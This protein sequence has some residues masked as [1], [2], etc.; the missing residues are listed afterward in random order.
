MLDPKLEDSLSRAIDL[1]AESLHEFVSLEHVLLALLENSEAKE[2][3]KALSVDLDKLRNHLQDFL[4]KDLPRMENQLA[5]KDSHWKPELTIAFHR[6]LQRAAIQVQS[7][8]R[9]SVSTGSLLVSLM[10]EKDSHAVYFIEQQGVTQFDIINYLSHGI[11]KNSR[12]PMETKKLAIDGL[13]QEEAESV[14]GDPLT[15]FAVNL[16]EKVKA[17]KVDPLIGRADVIERAIQILSRRTKNNPLLVGEAGVGKTAIADGLAQKIVDKE[18]PPHLQNAVIYSLDLG[19]LIAGTKYRGDFEQR[20]KSLLQALAEKD[21]PILFIDEIHTLVG[22]GGTSGGAMDAS[23]LLKPALADGSLSCIGSTTYK[24]FKNH[25]EKDRALARRFQKIDLKEPTVEETIEILKGLKKNYEDFHQVKYSK[26]SIEAA[27]QL[28]AKH[29][30]GRQLPDKAID[31]IDE[32]G[33]RTRIKSGH[34]SISVK[35]VERVVA[36]MAQIPTQSVSASDKEKLKTLQ[37]DLKSVIFGQDSAIDKL[38][39]A[40]KLSRTGLGREQKPIGSF[41]FAG[42]TGVG[43]TEVAKQLAKNLSIPFLRFDMSE[44]ME[45]H[46]VSRLIGAPPGYVGFEEGGLLTDSVIKNPHSV[47]LMDEIEKA[48]IDLIN[49][50]LQVMDSGR[51]TDSTGRTVDFSNVILILTSNTGAYEASRATLGIQSDTSSSKSMDAIKKSF[52]PEFLN[53]LDA[54]IEFKELNKELLTKVVKKFVE[55]LAAQLKDK[56]IDLKISTEAIHWLFEKGHQPAY[57]AR[58]FARTIDEHVKK[59]LVEDILFGALAQ[60]GEVFVD[61][62]DDQLDFQF[63]SKNL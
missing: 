17:G 36:A 45:K 52:T 7:S 15:S 57:G 43:K 9:N 48:H 21:N 20:L 18:V 41:L 14:K 54:V 30:Q 19:A 62:K 63:T 3:F 51:L 24:E 4:N 25:F 12:S 39:T 55:E 28:S 5:T 22:A 33:A 47:L 40:I 31:V 42:P 32:V 59:P 46:A 2:I 50:L 8:G 44:Y 53:R 37:T 56:K 38:V 34:K 27:A 23:N 10:T 1:A 29:I 58:P 61:L 26:S 13:P 35:D 11:S 16:N 60:G 49:I 6:I